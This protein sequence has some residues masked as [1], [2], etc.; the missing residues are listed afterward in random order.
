MAAEAS[1]DAKVPVTLALAKLALLFGLRYLTDSSWKDFTTWPVVSWTS[2]DPPTYLGPDQDHH[3]AWI[4]RTGRLFEKVAAIRPAVKRM[5]SN[6][7][8]NFCGIISRD[9]EIF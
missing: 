2:V 8:A 9:M 5:R 6:L 3:A 1:A 7:R 4:A